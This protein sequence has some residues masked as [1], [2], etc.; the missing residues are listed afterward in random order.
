MRVKYRLLI[1]ILCVLLVGCEKKV[2]NLENNLIIVNQSPI[3]FTSIEIRSVAEG[4]H[5]DALISGKCGYQDEIEFCVEQNFGNDI[6]IVLNPQE[7]YS[8]SKEIKKF[9]F[10]KATKYIIKIRNNEIYLEDCEL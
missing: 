2:E 7:G 1:G 8:V 10:D 9:N 3:V 6:K 4:N 5:I